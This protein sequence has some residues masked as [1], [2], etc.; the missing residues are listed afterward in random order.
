VGNFFALAFRDKRVKV[1]LA[2]ALSN[3]L[4]CNL[5]QEVNKVEKLL[6]TNFRICLLYHNLFVS[7]MWV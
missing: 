1:C 7:S 6:S 5:D 2:A 4:T 3:M